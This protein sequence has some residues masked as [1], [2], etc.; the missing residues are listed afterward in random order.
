M[1]SI[2]GKT[3][4]ASM[5][6]DGNTE[7]NSIN[8]FLLGSPLFGHQQNSEDLIYAPLDDKHRFER[9]QLPRLGKVT[10]NYPVLAMFAGR[11]TDAV[12]FEY[13]PNRRV[14]EDVVRRTWLLDEPGL[15]FGKF[16]HVLNGLRYIPY[17]PIRE[18]I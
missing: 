9:Y 11:D 14:T 3:D 13:T 2:L 8:I 12:W 4:T 18:V 6:N 10:S 16:G 15:I 5:W 7:R 17:L 1:L